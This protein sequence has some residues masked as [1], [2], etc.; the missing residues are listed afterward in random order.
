MILKRLRDQKETH[1]LVAEN[2]AQQLENRIS[3]RRAMKSTMG[4]S[5]KA[6]A[7]ESRLHVQDVLAALIWLVPSSTAKE[8]FRF[9]HYEQ[10][11]TMVLQRQIQPMVKSVLKPGSIMVK[12][13]QPKAKNPPG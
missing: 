11:L 5:M 7:K 12:Y 1:Q 9:R 2:I 8:I 4:R 10:I 6:G 3:F 13:F